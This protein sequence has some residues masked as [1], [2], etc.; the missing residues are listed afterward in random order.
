MK[1]IALVVDIKNWAFDLAAHIIKN[2]LSDQFKIDIFC[3]K[4]E[5]YQNDLFK[6]LEIVK[7]YD[8]IHFFWRAILLDFEKTEFKD[9]VI[10]KYG[11]YNSYI[12]KI[13][14]K[15]STGVYDHLYIED[16]NFNRIFSTYCRQYVTSSQK[17]FS[18]YEGMPNIKKP[19]C[20][21]GDSF[22]KELFYPSSLERFENYFDKNQ[23]LVIGWVGN[24]QWNS[25][26]KDS[27]GNPT[28]FKGFQAILKPVIEELQQENYNIKLLLADK[29]LHFI[30]NEKLISF[31]SQLHIYTCV[32]DCEGTPKPL[33]EAIGCAIP[34][35]C[36]DVGIAQEALGEKQKQYILGE[37]IIGK[38]DAYIKNQLKEKIKFL[39]THRERL[40]ELSQENYQSSQKYEIQ[41]MKKVY[42]NYFRSMLV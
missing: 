32:S 5:E 24:S 8:I 1:K 40:K 29:N 13:V 39:Y 28:D 31:Y 26:I 17:L 6:V 10:E 41:Q 27:N 37:R 33:L 18:I 20:I 3:S 22:E 12:Q 16:E 30:P 19:S 36:T 4:S 2:H 38:N 21:M 23:E 42:E 11:D 7:D 25:S 15:I 34:V 14:P 35:I 9:K